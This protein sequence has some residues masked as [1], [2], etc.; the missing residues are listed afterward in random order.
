MTTP[1]VTVRE[2]CTLQEAAELMMKRNIGCLPVVDEKGEI[3]GIVTESDFSAKEKGIPFSLCRFPQ[4]LG[5]WLPRQGVEEIYAKARKVPVREI[6][7][8]DVVAVAPDDSIELVLERMLEKRVHRVPVLSG[9]RPVG[10]VT[11]RDLLRLML[12]QLAPAA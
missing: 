1:A 5:E 9:N 10:V 7:Q 8:P 3:A 11:R 6:M 12:V 2:D 4:V